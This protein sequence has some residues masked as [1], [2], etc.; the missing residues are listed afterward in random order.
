MFLGKSRI[1]IMPIPGA[2]DKSIFSLLS[3]L[4]RTIIC[5]IGQLV[6]HGKRDVAKA[7]L[8]GVILVFSS[9]LE[10]KAIPE[11]Q[12]TE[13]LVYYAHEKYVSTMTFDNLMH[14][15]PNS[16]QNGRGLAAG[17]I[18]SYWLA[19]NVYKYKADYYNKYYSGRISMN[20]IGDF[21]STL[22]HNQ[23]KEKLQKGLLNEFVSNAV[24][25][26]PR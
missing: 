7:I 21:F 6:L 19:L 23:E 25:K 3:V 16:L 5:G 22:F 14:L 8:D 4:V 20:V 17:E 24:S 15:V 18:F 1:C 12:D 10:P 9:D 11:A 2:G 26:A 13:P